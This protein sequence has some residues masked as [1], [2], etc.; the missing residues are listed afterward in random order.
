MNLVFYSG[1]DEKENGLIDQLMINLVKTKN[2]VI[3]FVPSSS[4]L[5][6]YDFQEFVRRFSKFKI[7]KFIHFPVDIYYDEVMLSQVMKSDLIY[8]DGGNTFYFLNSLRRSGFLQELKKYIKNGG[9]ISG[10]SA[11]AIM[12]TDDIEM[13]AYPEFDRD[14][15]EIH[16]KNLK[17]LGFVDFYFFPHF[18]KSKRYETAFKKYSKKSNK[19]IYACP[20]GSGIIVQDETIQFIG[21]CTAFYQG[22]KIIIND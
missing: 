6:E 3:T 18:K 19:L 16:L 12:M 5:S 10:L 14:S 9:I 13:A 4:Y 21:K 22:Q 17:S 15:N 11:G 1:G 7:S 2:P 20:N 8:L